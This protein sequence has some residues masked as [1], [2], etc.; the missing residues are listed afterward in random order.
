M[1]I[2]DSVNASISHGILR[3][4]LH[5]T[6][7]RLRELAKAESSPP[8]FDVFVDA[9]MTLIANLAT[10]ASGTSMATGAGLVPQMLELACIEAPTNYLV[11]RTS[12]RAVGLLDSILYAYPSTFQQFTA[13]H[14][15]DVLVRLSLIHISEPTRPSHISRMPSSA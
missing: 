12:T 8:S 2:R 15:I 7:Q 13:S 4:L 9:L 3:Q 10:V 5:C 1:C 14:G 6:I 11:Q